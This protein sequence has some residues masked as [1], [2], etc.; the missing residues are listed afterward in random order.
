MIDLRPVAGGAENKIPASYEFR[1]FWWREQLVG[2]GRYW[3]EAAGYHWTESE[4]QSALAIAQQ[5][6]SAI[7]CTFL[8][9]DLA[10][11]VDGDWVIIECND[12]MESGYAGASPFVIWDKIIALETQK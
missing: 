2:S 6:V 3:F 12:G 7:N 10:Q 1:T 11:T 8:V 5:A 9:I 4:M